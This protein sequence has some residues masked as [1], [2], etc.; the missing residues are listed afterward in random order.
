MQKRVWPELSTAGS[1][2][3]LGTYVRQEERQYVTYS[4]KTARQ[5]AAATSPPTSVAMARRHGLNELST[6]RLA[7]CVAC[8][9]RKKRTYSCGQPEN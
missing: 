2:R 5:A 3:A 4:M 7:R 1:Q 8:G 6:R 9:G